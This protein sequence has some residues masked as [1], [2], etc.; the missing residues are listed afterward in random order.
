MTVLSSTVD[1]PA[2]TV[3]I[4]ASAPRVFRF[5]VDAAVKDALLNGLDDITETLRLEP[6]VSRCER[7]HDTHLVR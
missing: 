7:T 1:L 2:Q 5:E 4:H 6:G 3:T